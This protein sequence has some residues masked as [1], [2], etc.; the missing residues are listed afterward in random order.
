MQ[1]IAHLGSCFFPHPFFSLSDSN[2]FSF[3]NFKGDEIQVKARVAVTYDDTFYL[4]EVSRINSNT[5]KVVVN[6][7]A[8]SKDG[9]YRWPKKED[10]DEV[11]V[12]FISFT[13]IELEGGFLAEEDEI[14][15]DF[16]QYKN[17]YML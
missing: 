11:E 1:V 6:F 8:R 10:T 15:P 4:G 16:F 2:D 13:N 7:M 3:H 9:Y 5:K 14:S 12:N 17:D